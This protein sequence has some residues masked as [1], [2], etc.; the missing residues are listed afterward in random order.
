[1]ALN[2]ILNEKRTDPLANAAIMLV[3][4]IGLIL[5]MIFGSACAVLGKKTSPEQTSCQLEAVKVA[6]DL[7]DPAWNE[8]QAVKK[9]GLASVKD[10]HATFELV[11]A[12]MRFRD[13]WDRNVLKTENPPSCTTSSN[14]E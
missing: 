3:A 9:N 10:L 2:K 6:A 7:L 11:G 1:M 5:M 13:C 14:L 4:A 12:A 8:L